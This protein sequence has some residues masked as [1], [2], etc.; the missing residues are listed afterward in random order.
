MK[1][2]IGF[3]LLSALTFTACK[4]ESETDLPEGLYANIETDKG[5]I[6][7]QL[8]FEKTPVTVANFVA[9]AEG[10]HPNVDAKYKDKPYYDG[11]SFHRVISDFMIQTGDPNGD[12]TGGP[13]YDFHDEI[14]EDLK[15][16]KAGILSMANRGQAT[17]G[18]QFFITHN[19]TPHLNGKHTVFGHVVEGQE[20]VN[21]IAQGDKIVSVKII[22]SGKNAVSFDAAKTFAEGVENY[23]SQTQKVITE[24]SAFLKE[25][26][27]KA[28]QVKDVK[29]HV[30]ETGDGEKPAEGENV[31]IDYAGYLEDGN[32]FDTSF[33]E[34]AQKFNMLDIQRKDQNGY[35]PIPFVY[36]NDTG[37]IEGFI[38]GVDHLSY[39]DKALVFIPSH[40][41]YKERGV[42]GVIPPNSDLV[43][44][45][46]LVKK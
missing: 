17:N 5:E 9:L 44:E 3:L 36:G 35:R 26:K 20:V 34:I 4:K 14:V 24:N 6:L 37:L 43:F 41:A 21:T 40:L 38:Q 25:A 2:I 29:I 39:G 31:L 45:I 27:E 1:K 28:V 18:S 15:H 42:P 16:D 22:R 8:E 7:L 32:L 10:T 12:G 30:F 33:P 19:A 13:G 11:L 23:S 46:H